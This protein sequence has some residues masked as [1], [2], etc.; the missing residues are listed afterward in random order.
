MKEVYCPKCGG[1]MHKL[2][3]ECR[4]CYSGGVTKVR[5]SEWKITKDKEVIKKDLEIFDKLRG[6]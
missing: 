4:R 1:I 6:V 2:S 3:H 5:I